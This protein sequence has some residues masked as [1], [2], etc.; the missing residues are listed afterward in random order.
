MAIADRCELR[1]ANR[2]GTDIA[3]VIEATNIR[4]SVELGGSGSLS[5]DVDARSS[6]IAASPGILDDCVIRLAIPLA[7]AE[8][9]TNVVAYANRARNGVLWDRGRQVRRIIGAPTLWT[10]WAQDAVLYPETNVLAQMCGEQ[11]YF[12]WQASIYDPATDAGYTWET[13]SGSAGTQASATG[14]R[15]GKPDDWPAALDGATWITRGTTNAGMRHLFVAD[16]T[17]ATAAMVKLWFSADESCAVYFAGEL[18]IQ[19]SS[20]ETGY[21]SMD[22]WQAWVQPGTYRV[23]IDKTSIVS[24]GGDGI[25]PVLLAVATITDA[26]AVSTV[27]LTTNTTDWQVHTMPI[28]GMAPAL[29]PGQIALE[30]HAQAVDRG[31]NTWDAVTPDF[32]AA[33]DSA[34]VDWPVREERTWRV[35]Y[36]TGLDML[37]G[38]GDLGFCPEITPA[39]TFKAWSAR[40]S[41]LSATV[42]IEALVSADRVEETGVGVLA[43]VLPVETQDGWVTV[44]NATAV[45]TYGRREQGLSLGNAPS[46]AQGKR[47]GQRVLDERLARPTTEWTVEFYAI[48]GCVPFRDFNLGDTVTVKIGATSTPRVVLAIGGAAKHVGAIT[49]FTL[50]TGPVLS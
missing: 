49:R 14:K 29:T 1:L 43:T 5:C 10:A 16:V 48:A 47:L 44:S 28:D 35:I 22:T 3:T 9:P 32:T 27:L 38:L 26:D 12:G 41:N 40:G 11:R 13:P 21:E 23:G 37:E 24:R 4:W 8:S 50:S 6:V 20:S 17:I 46:I 7:A 45:A 42:T 18:V 25:D 31:V 30:L 2:F 39:L 33:A 19:T 36:D 34:A 15:A